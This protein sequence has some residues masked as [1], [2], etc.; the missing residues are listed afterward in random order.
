MF[1]A[2]PKR[3]P[4]DRRFEGVERRA[5][6]PVTDRQPFWKRIPGKNVY[7]FADRITNLNLNY[8]F[9]VAFRV[10]NELRLDPTMTLEVDPQ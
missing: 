6:G 3:R 8:E 5:K 2:R 10:K 7:V 1:D 9:E 4:A